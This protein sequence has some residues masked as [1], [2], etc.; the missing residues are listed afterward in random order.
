MNCGRAPTI[1]T[2]RMLYFPPPPPVDWIQVDSSSSPGVLPNHANRVP[3]EPQGGPIIGLIRYY[4]FCGRDGA[5]QPKH[6]RRTTAGTGDI[7]QHEVSVWK[8]PSPD[9]A[10]TV[11][12]AAARRH[13][14]PHRAS[15]PLATGHGDRKKPP[16]PHSQPEA[17][18]CHRAG[19]SSDTPNFH[20]AK[21]S[22]QKQATGAVSGQRSYSARAADIAVSEGV[23]GLFGRASVHTSYED[24]VTT[25]LYGTCRHN[26]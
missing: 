6:S 20:Y 4:R 1:V 14:T 23:A 22:H 18:T 17:S 2:K 11:R 7:E 13:T 16:V 10:R 12:S 24:K 26:R 8:R 3:P 25:L 15:S 5:C 21:G 9:P 19:Y